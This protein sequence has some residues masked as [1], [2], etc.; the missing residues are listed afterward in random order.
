MNSVDVFEP[1][2]S[3]SKSSVYGF[4]ASTTIFSSQPSSSPSASSRFVHGT[5]MST[6]SLASTASWPVVA[7]AFEPISAISP[8][9]DSGPRELAIRTS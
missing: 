7:W 8:F 2:S 1:R 4:I 9:S 6:T 5:A 3:I